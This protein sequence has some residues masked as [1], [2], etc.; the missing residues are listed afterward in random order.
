MYTA[1]AN[2]IKMEKSLHDL[3]DYMEKFDDMDNKYNGLKATLSN[4]TVKKFKEILK[5]E[6]SKINDKLEDKLRQLRQYK[7]QNR[8]IAAP[9]EET[10]KYSP[11]E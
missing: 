7:K 10:E 4:D 8:A 5:E 6:I 1:R 3:R 2:Y 9:C 11:G